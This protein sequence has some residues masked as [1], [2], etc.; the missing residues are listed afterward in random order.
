M[1]RTGAERTRAARP[2][3]TADAL[4]HL[5]LEALIRVHFATGGDGHLDV[6]DAIAEGPIPIEQPFHR[7][8]RAGN[9]LRV[10]EAVDPKQKVSSAGVG[11]NRLGVFVDFWVSTEL[12][13]P[14]RIDTHGEYTE[15]HLPIVNAHPVDLRL[16]PIDVQQRRQEVPH[17]GER[18]EPDEI[19]TKQPAQHLAAPRQNPKDFRRGKWDVQKEADAGI[20]QPLA[21]QP[22]Q[23]HELIVVNPN[24]VVGPIFVRHGISK[25][26]VDLPACVPPGRIHRN[27]IDQI[28]KQRP[29]DPIGEAAVVPVDLVPRKRDGHDCVVAEL[30]LEVRTLMGRE[31]RQVA[32][33]SNPQPVRVLVMRSQAVCETSAGRRQADVIVLQARDQRQAIRHNHESALHP[34]HANMN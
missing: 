25:R 20:R 11:T 18:V 26:L 2:V 14:C 12:R 24:G 15:P 23:Q 28:V 5:A 21:Q 30:A 34:F 10:V 19:G 4:F 27:A 6:A 32:R 22:R 16:D 1:K 31:L 29:Q 9:A 33:P 17:V 13:K 3:D 7:L 8:K